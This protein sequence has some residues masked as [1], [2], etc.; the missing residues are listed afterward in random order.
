MT[1]NGKRSSKC[2]LRIGVPQGS[3]LGPILFILYT[4]ELNLIAGKYGFSIHLYADDTQLYIE[5][6]PLVQNF[7]N[8]EERIIA[9]LQD[10]KNWME[11][12]KLKLNP[13][14]TEAL[15]TQ[16]RNNFHTFTVEDIQLGQAN[17]KITPSPVVKSLGV[18]FD[19]YLTFEKQVDMIVKTCNI[20]LRNLRVIGSKLTLSVEKIPVVM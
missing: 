14:K 8:I 3:I 13:D 2:Y 4:K 19:E 11:L 18:L 17:E 10:I 1:I 20:H 15:L 16:T 9:C 12:N 5:F 7:S 6:N